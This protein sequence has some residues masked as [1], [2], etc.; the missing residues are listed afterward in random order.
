MWYVR[1]PDPNIIS[2][3][4]RLAEYPFIDNTWLGFGHRIE[5]P[6][7]PV[8]GSD[9]RIFLFLTPII[10]P[11]KRIAEALTID[12]DDVEILCVH[13]ISGAEYEFIRTAGLDPF[14]DMLD[15][16]HYPT[17]FNPKRTS[18]A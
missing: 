3:L 14:L 16:R 7:S 18:Y 2:N 4:K 15:E 9:F 8:T 11:D 17:V 6:W 10:A 12:D 1:E 5:M 13:L